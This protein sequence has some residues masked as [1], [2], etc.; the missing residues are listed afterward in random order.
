MEDILPR[1]GSDWTD[2][3]SRYNIRAS[4]PRSADSLKAKFKSLVGSKKPTG[5][6]TKSQ[7]ITK[8]HQVQ[9][10]IEARVGA[11]TMGLVPSESPNECQ[12]EDG[13]DPV[14]PTLT[15]QIESALSEVLSTEPS[16][17]STQSAL[18]SPVPQSPV[19]QSTRR[20]PTEALSST[21]AK[22]RKIDAAIAALSTP[23]DSSINSIFAVA[24]Q[25]QQYQ[26]QQQVALAEA[27][28][29]RAEAQ[30][31]F[32]MEMLMKQQEMQREAAQQ[33]NQMLLA[34]LA[35]K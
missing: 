7:T 8:A 23:T 32:Q 12:S 16:A 24:L 28:Q 19:P 14:Q 17:S 15:E 11:V 6:S 33:F 4:S 21:G 35:K 26:A 9:E 20:H 22:R 27:A 5:T 10:L 34:L 2:V 31:Q 25:Q 18:L 30:Q 13:D 3:E 29:R 1:G